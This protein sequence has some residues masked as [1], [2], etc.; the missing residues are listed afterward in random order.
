MDSDTNRRKTIMASDILM[1]QDQL[2]EMIKE[3][4]KQF[5]N[6]PNDMTLIEQISDI[7]NLKPIAIVQTHIDDNVTAEK[8]I[9]MKLFFSNEQ[10]QTF[11]EAKNEQAERMEFYRVKLM[12]FFEQEMNQVYNFLFENYDEI[13]YR[14][15][16]RKYEIHKRL[17]YHFESKYAKY[18]VSYVQ[19]PAL[20][21]L[22]VKKEE[23]KIKLLKEVAP[24]TLAKEKH[25]IEKIC[26]V[27]NIFTEYEE[28][29]KIM[30]EEEIIKEH[31][32]MAKFYGVNLY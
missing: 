30:S 28:D 4:E 18:N 31:G 17:K 24:F 25:S 6:G 16:Y 22:I 1:D 14:Y 19:Y 13:Y 26:D 23:D 5:E 9:E 3:I 8:W 20:N 12:L 15:L 2:E 21:V 29:V 27:K 11:G 7:I 32:S 10:L